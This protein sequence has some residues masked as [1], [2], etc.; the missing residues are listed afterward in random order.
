MAD[1]DD[2]GIAPP[3]ELLHGVLGRAAGGGGVGADDGLAGLV[4]L[5]SQLGVALRHGVEA[6]PAV[7]QQANDSPGDGG[8]TRRG[9]AAG[10]RGAGDGIKNAQSL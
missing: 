10:G 4:L 6:A 2:D 8:D 1:A 5:H 9:L 7:A 3:R